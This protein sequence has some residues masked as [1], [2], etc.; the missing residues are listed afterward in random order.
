MDGS[1]TMVDHNIAK[2]VFSD[3]SI[4]FFFFVL[5][6]GLKKADIVLLFSLQEVKMINPLHHKRWCIPKLIIPL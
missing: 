5:N 2:A 1:V 4:T 3:P 6:F